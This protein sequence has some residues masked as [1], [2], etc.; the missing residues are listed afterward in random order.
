MERSRFS[1]AR[2]LGIASQ[3]KLVHETPMSHSSGWIL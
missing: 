1:G 2:Q 3:K